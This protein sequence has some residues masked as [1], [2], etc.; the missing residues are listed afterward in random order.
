M[1]QPGNIRQAV[2][3]GGGVITR[4]SRGAKFSPLHGKPKSRAGG[5]RP[6]AAIHRR[7]RQDAA[8][9]GKKREHGRL[10]FFYLADPDHGEGAVPPPLSR[11]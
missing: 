2:K 7:G 5:V 3:N 10:R 1:F 9:R 6:I 8:L 11:L 4:V